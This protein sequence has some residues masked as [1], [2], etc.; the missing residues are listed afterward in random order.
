MFSDLHMHS[1]FSD[2]AL[3]PSELVDRVVRAGI[4]CMSLTDHD[5]VGGLSEAEEA[6][7]VAGIRFIPGVEISTMIDQSEVHLLGYA[8]DRGVKELG[9]FLEEQRQRRRSRITEFIST[10]KGAGVSMGDVTIDENRA[11]ALGRPHVAR[12]IVDG[13]SAA[14]VAEAFEKYLVP[15]TPTF[16]PRLMPTPSE[17]IDVIHASGG[18]VSVAHPGD[19]TPH[20]VMMLLIDAG[21]DGIEV[22]HP[23]HDT[24]LVAYYSELADKH[25]LF[26]TGGS[27]FHGWREGDE[28]NLGRIGMDWDLPSKFNS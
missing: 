10:L 14:S 1:T 5:T 15:G 9:L 27:D 22:N 13:G 12:M 28:E 4:S 16:V 19:F 23:S 11:G 25:G 8:Y 24:R 20:R 21:L 6:C 2:G 18:V 3:A 17:A 26:R 7:K